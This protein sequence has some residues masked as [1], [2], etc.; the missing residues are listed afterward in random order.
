MASF[1]FKGKPLSK[2]EDD[3]LGRGGERKEVPF[4]KKRKN[5]PP[6]AKKGSTA[7]SLSSSRR[8]GKGGAS[9]REKKSVRQAGKKG[10]TILGALKKS[11]VKGSL[12]RRKKTHRPN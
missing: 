1:F 9:K 11:P 5:E 6:F 7:L 10:E 4:W 12:M 2:K 8:R 3:I